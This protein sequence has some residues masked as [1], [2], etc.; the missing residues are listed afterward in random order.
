MTV[1]IT[2]VW[3]ALKSVGVEDEKARRAAEAVADYRAG[4]NERLDNG[5]AEAE[6]RDAALRQEMRDE[7]GGLRQEMRDEIGKLRQEMRDGDA[8]LAAEIKL[9]KWMSGATFAGVVAILLRL[10]L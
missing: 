5:F 9:L 4:F 10:F 8:T 1:M 7:I 2:E 6:R 3:D